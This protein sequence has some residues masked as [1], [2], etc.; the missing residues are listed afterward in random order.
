MVTVVCVQ[1]SVEVFSNAWNVWEGFGR[2]KSGKSTP[3]GSKSDLAVAVLRT[4]M[5]AKVKVTFG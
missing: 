4:L 5:A 3:R 2:S 1:M